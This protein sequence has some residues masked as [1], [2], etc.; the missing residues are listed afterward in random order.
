MIMTAVV[1]LQASRRR[2]LIVARSACS[3]DQ[4]FGQLSGSHPAEAGVAFHRLRPGP[5]K[6]SEA[7]VPPNPNEFDRT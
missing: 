2:N 5:P 4:R 6:I 1:K 3:H 7:L